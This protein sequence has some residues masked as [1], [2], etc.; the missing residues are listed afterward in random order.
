MVDPNFAK[1]QLMLIMREWYMKPDGQ[2]PA[3]EWHFSDVN[4]PVQ[5]WAALQVYHIEKK[6]T[7][8]GDIAFLKRVFPETADQFYLVDQSKRCC[9]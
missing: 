4:P 8:K 9:R 3:Y 1:N 2:L 7:G 6:N 5:A